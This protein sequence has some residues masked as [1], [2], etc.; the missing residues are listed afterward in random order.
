MSAIKQPNSENYQ[1]VLQA[2]LYL[3]KVCNHPA[4]VLSSSHPKHGE[5]MN[6]LTQQR[7]SLHDLQHAP[8][9]TA[10]RSVVMSKLLLKVVCVMV[11]GGRGGM[12]VC[13]CVCVCVCARA[14]ACV[15][16]C[17][18]VCLCAH[19]CACMCVCTHTYAHIQWHRLYAYAIVQWPDLTDT[20]TRMKQYGKMTL[21]HR[22]TIFKLIASH[23]AM[24]LHCRQLLLDCGIGVCGSSGSGSCV[25]AETAVDADVP[26]VGEHRV[27]LFCQLKTMLDIVEKDLLKYGLCLCLPHC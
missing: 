6:R 27:L 2:L 24:T 3:R 9:L 14:R 19:A 23:S 26:V 7:T 4:L 20:Q 18:C 8:K 25:S 21:L 11:C 17:V 5:I 1:C 22:L 13:V 10:L 12:C 16:V 15:R